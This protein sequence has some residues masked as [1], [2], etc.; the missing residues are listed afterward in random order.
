MENKAKVSICIPA[1]K[2]PDCLSRALE[3]IAIQ[4]FKDYE[5]I[6]TDDTPDDSVKQAVEKFLKISPIKYYKNEII[7]GSPGNW[8]AAVS[9]ASGEYIKILHHDDWFVSKDSLSKFVDLLDKNPGADFGFC[10]FYNIKQSG[11]KELHLPA[12]AD[13]KKL[14]KKP[15]FIYPKNFIGPPSAVIYRKAASLDYD[16]KLKWV[17][18]LD[19]YYRILKNNPK[20][21]FCQDSLVNITSG[22]ADQV[23]FASLNNK[24]V[25]IFEWLYLYEKM[26]LGKIPTPRAAL[27]LYYLMKKHKIKSV[28]EAREIYPDLKA[29][30]AALLKLAIISPNL[31]AF[32]K[33]FKT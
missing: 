8:N 3:S 14:L 9:K 11:E 24:R 22:S 18:D 17:V 32:R 23:T 13:L 12:E 6:I 2:L 10:S 28:S 5:V 27:F 26:F 16:K 21:A 33:Y 25:E 7:Q 29:S 31:V 20:F 4:S 19:F 30:T 1:Y 15:E